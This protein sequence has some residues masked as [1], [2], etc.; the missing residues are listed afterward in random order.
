MN[1]G[2]VIPFKTDEFKIYGERFL[3]AIRTMEKV[4]EKQ[5][6]FNM[7]NWLLKV[8]KRKDIH[9]YI[10]SGDENHS[11]KTIGCMIGWI[12]SSKWHNRQGF[13]LTL[14]DDFAGVKRHIP[15]YGEY[16]GMYA[17]SKYFNISEDEVSYLFS[18]WGRNSNFTAEQALQH[19]KS[20]V[21]CK[22]VIVA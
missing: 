10:V 20:F 5:K 8:K 11:C 19:L 9:Q 7:K 21:K 2:N 18:S 16:T 6:P 13:G 3:R 1:L 14:D 15:S 4:V 17:I 12:G 22:G